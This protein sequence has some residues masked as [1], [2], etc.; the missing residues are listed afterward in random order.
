[1]HESGSSLFPGTGSVDELGAGK[2]EGFAV[3]A[4]LDHG[5]GDESWWSVVD[6]MLPV[7]A[8]MF[9]P[10]FIVSQ[11]G[12]DTHV[13]D[14]LAHL[15][16]TTASYQRACTLVDRLAHEHAEGRWF[17]TGGGGYDA[18]RVVPRSWALVWLAQAH[19]RAADQD[20]RGLARALER[21]CRGIRAGTAAHW[22]S[23]TSR[24]P[25]RPIP[26]SSSPASS[27]V[28]ARPCCSRFACRRSVKT[29]T[30]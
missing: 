27:S 9:K 5:V 15:R 23:S 16:V 21:R 10:T 1:M 14:P 28:P 26:M 20:P 7:L 6:F 19:R 4:P 13:L 25:W 12:C 3:N 30:R 29:S 18:F 22:S 2:G 24:A 8:D 17:A 11:H